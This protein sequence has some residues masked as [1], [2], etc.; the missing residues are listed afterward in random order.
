MGW[1]PVMLSGLVT[2]SPYIPVAPR[3]LDPPTM[4]F[5]TGDSPGTLCL[6]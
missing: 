4:A 2:P 3:A 1:T 6:I 5:L